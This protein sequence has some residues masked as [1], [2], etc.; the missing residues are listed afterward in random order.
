MAEGGKEAIRADGAVVPATEIGG[1]TPDSQAG[2]YT[3]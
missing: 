1:E 2:P 3:G